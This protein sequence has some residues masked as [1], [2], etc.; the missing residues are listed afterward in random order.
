[1][2]RMPLF[3]LISGFFAHMLLEKRG[4]NGFSKNRMARIFLPFAVFLPLVTVSLVGEIIWAI[5]VVEHPSPFLQLVTVT[6]VI[7]DPENNERQLPF[8]TGHLWFLYNL[9]MFC[10]LLAL[11]WKVKLTKLKWLLSLVTPKFLLFVLPLLLIP[12]LSSVATPYPAPDSLVPELWSFGFFGIFFVLGFILYHKQYLLD[13]L[14]LY[15]PFLLLSSI[16]LYIYYFFQVKD[17]STTWASIYDH[18]F[19]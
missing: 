1:M 11:M 4:V 8:S 14:K 7:T 13:E 10:G 9:L 12:A 17:V 6:P 5:E 18:E 2:F 3:F 19:L 15:A 16:A